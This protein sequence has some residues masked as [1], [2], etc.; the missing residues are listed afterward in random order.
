MNG[1]I[2]S[3]FLLILIIIIVK[4]F[5][6]P[7]KKKKRYVRTGESSSYVNNHNYTHSIRKDIYEKTN[8]NNDKDKILKGMDYEFY[9]GDHFE[10]QGYIV[11]YHGIKNGKKDKG[12]DLIAK[13]GNEVIFIQCKNWKKDGRKININHIKA[14]LADTY[15]YIEDNPMYKNYN[16]KRI[17]T[18]SNPILTKSAYAYIKN[19][20]DKLQY[21]I[22]KMHE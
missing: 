5:T 3:A 6:K 10:N 19:N 21:L 7:K 11:T 9:V 16:I 13:K 17:Y 22:L 20:Q 1:D 2:F 12:I 15:N 18:I 14:F 8:I 4:E